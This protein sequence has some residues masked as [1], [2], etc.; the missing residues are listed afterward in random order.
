MILATTYTAPE[1]IAIIGAISALIVTVLTA[2]GNLIIAWHTSNKVAEVNKT[3]AVIEGH[4][5]SQTTKLVTEADALRNENSQLRQ[6]LSETKTTA[7]VLTANAANGQT[8]GAVQDKLS[9]IAAD[10]AETKAAAL[11]AVPAPRPPDA[12]DRA[13]DKG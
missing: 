12:R 11:A 13:T 1:M 10:I 5:N 9:S 8:A 4:V 3:T 6:T 2:I 7:A